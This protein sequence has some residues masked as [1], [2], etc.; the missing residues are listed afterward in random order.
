MRPIRLR[1]LPLHLAGSK[2]RICNK[3]IIFELPDIIKTGDLKFTHCR[4]CMSRDGLWLLDFNGSRDTS[5]VISE[6]YS[7]VVGTLNNE[8]DLTLHNNMRRN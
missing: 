5:C 3:R 4:G 1:G 2:G 7:S 6:I 8:T